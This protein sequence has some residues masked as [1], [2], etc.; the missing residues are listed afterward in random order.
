M[1]STA[2]V[3]KTVSFLVC[4]T[5]FVAKTLRSPCGPQ[6]V[7]EDDATVSGPSSVTIVRYGLSSTTMDL[8]TSGLG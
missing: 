6:A 2:F 8:I 5:A 1:R 3:A 7:G 4:S